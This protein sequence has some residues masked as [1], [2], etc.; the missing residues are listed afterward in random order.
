MGAAVIIRAIL[1]SYADRVGTDL[2]T[3]SGDDAVDFAALDSSAIVVLCHDG[4][5]DPLFVYANQAAATL[6]RTPAA[7]LIGSPSRLTAP[8]DQQ[9]ERTEALRTAMSA[10]VL[11]GYSGER[12]ARD[13]S[14]FVIRHAVLWTVDGL[15]GGAGQAAMFTEW[16]HLE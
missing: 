15:P 4:A 7:E 1:D 13:G 5:D 12:R 14:R 10:G 11:Y 3:R 9:A 2:I 16:E 6:W 8:A